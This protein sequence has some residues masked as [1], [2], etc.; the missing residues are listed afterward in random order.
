MLLTDSHRAARID[1]SGELVT[2]DKQ[3][4]SGWNATL[5]EEGHALVRASVEA[6]QPGPYQLQAAINAVHTSAR[7]VTDTDWTALATLYDQLYSLQPT[8]VVALNRAV[9]TAELDGPERSLAAVDALPLTGYHAFHATRAELLRRLGRTAEAH[10][11]YT[12]AI[13]LARNPA[14]ARHLSRRRRELVAEP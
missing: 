14:E 5:I 7:K 2:L 11:A 3:D 8:P 9:V 10:A 6:N 12:R 13:E 4:R 1:A